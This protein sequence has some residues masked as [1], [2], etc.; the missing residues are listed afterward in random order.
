M[1]V[2]VVSEAKGKLLALVPID[3]TG[4][5]SPGGPTRTWVSPAVGQLVHE[6]ELT[7]ELARLD[8]RVLFARYRVRGRPPQAVATGEPPE[9]RAAGLGRQGRK[10]AG[11]KSTK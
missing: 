2:H 4:R 1:R 9:Q 3:L 6:I 8:P 10:R 5:T 11:R 7:D